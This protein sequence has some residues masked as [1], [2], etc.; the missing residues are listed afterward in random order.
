MEQSMP[1][2]VSDKFS[3]QKFSMFGRVKEN[4]EEIVGSVK[5]E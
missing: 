3:V 5:M 2:N 4:D 1:F